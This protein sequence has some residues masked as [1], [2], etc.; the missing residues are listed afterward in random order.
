MTTIRKST[1]AMLA[2]A[3]VAAAGAG[4]W[5]FSDSSA[6]SNTGDKKAADAEGTKEMAGGSI[7]EPVV[8]LVG[9]KAPDFKL[10]A[11]DGKSY[12]LKDHLAEGKVVVLEWFNPDC[13]VVQRYHK[14]S[15]KMAEAF[16]SA[17][18][19]D[20]A[21]LAINSGGPGQQ[22]HG[23]ERNR[24]AVTEYG[25]RY[26]VLLDE[27]GRVGKLYGA[28]TTPHLFIIDTAGT[29]IYKGSLD[30]RDGGGANYVLK[31]LEERFAG[32][33]VTTKETQSFGCNVKY[34][35]LGT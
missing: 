24:Q 16:K 6:G 4:L 28:K 27:D 23:L 5:G 14:S 29:L 19:R 21:W 31:A 9:G 7:S 17:S 8:A 32:K 2:F 22:G 34:A 13:P 18:G 33:D 12:A 30:D 15:Q 3:A 10:P 20:V 25:I 1:F 11:V 26:P 35:D